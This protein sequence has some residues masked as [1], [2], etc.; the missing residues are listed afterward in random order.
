MAYQS[1]DLIAREGAAPVMTQDRDEFL[2][3][4]EKA[5]GLLIN[6]GMPTEERYH[7]IEQM[8]EMPSNHPNKPFVVLDP[9]GCHTFSKRRQYAKR[10][11]KTGLVDL[12]KCNADEGNAL[13]QGVTKGEGMDS[14]AYP[15]NESLRIAQA[16]TEKYKCQVVL[17][18]KEDVYATSDSL[19]GIKHFGDARRQ[20]GTGCLLG[21]YLCVV[22]AKA[23]EAQVS[24][25]FPKALRQFRYAYLGARRIIYGI[26]PEHFEGDVLIT[27]TERLLRAGIHVIQYRSKTKDLARQKEEIRK[28][29]QRCQDYGVPLILNDHKELAL[30]LKVEGVHLGQ[31]DWVKEALLADPYPKDKILGMTAKTIEQGEAAQRAGADYLGVGALYPSQTKPDA[32]P[33]SIEN[34][35]AIRKKVS[36][37]LFGIG[38]L[39]SENLSDDLLQHLEGVVMSQSLY[40]DPET[41]HKVK[42]RLKAYENL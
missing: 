41:I 15:I 14:H 9:V 21:A 12:I 40:A 27:E 22:G 1:A 26:T 16:L 35:K 28:L 8:I 19:L 5:R 23:Q 25:D 39:T 33:L 17:T 18:G 29:H 34:L 11:L 6:L 38:G 36:L 10:L 32:I 24:P 2:E 31:S 37:P 7:L 20:V 3:I 30:E 42:A 4:Y 13:L